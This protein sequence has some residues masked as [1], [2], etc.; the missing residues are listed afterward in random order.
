[1]VF[2]LFLCR[3]SSVLANAR[4]FRRTSEFPFTRQKGN[5]AMYQAKDETQCYQW[6]Q[7]QTGIADPS[8]PLNS[9][10]HRA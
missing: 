6:A 1:M 9:R 4:S 3:E 8:N 2:V 7:K 5:Q 10:S